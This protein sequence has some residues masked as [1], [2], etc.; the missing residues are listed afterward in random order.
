MIV[1][2]ALFI[3]F[4]EVADEWGAIILQQAE[5]DHQLQNEEKR[6]YKE[7]QRLYKDFLD[8]QK[9]EA[10]TRRYTKIDQQMPQGESTL[11]IDSEMREY[12]FKERKKAATL[13]VLREMKEREQYNM[14]EK[15][16]EEKE[17]FDYNQFLNMM[18]QN[19]L[20]MQAFNKERRNHVVNSLRRSYGEQE[21]HK[22]QLSMAQKLN[23]IKL[24]EQQQQQWPVIDIERKRVIYIF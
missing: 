20:K 21:I 22:K 14:A 8:R 2:V 18:E 13:E 12:Q 6:L 23:D 17:K 24:L 15:A 4:L 7:R 5:A 10:G 3:D 9:N 11:G 16:K 19:D 1:L